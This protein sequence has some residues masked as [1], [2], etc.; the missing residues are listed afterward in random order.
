MLSAAS[1]IYLQSRSTVTGFSELPN[2]PRFSARDSSRISQQVWVVRSNWDRWQPIGISRIGVSGKGALSS[3]HLEVSISETPKALLAPSPRS[4]PWV[5]SG[6]PVKRGNP[7]YN[8]EY[9]LGRPSEGRAAR[10]RAISTFESLSY[11]H[12]ST[13]HI[14]KPRTPKRREHPGL[15]AYSIVGRIQNRQIARTRGAHPCHVGIWEFEG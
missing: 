12:S 7:F 13:F 8:S 6:E 3:L 4:Q 5:I 1:K 14:S 2:C 10:I 9:H 11:K 15:G